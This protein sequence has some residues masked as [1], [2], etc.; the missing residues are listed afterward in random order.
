MYVSSSC[1]TSNHIGQSV[2][3]LA[4]AGVRNIELSGGTSTYDDLLDDLLQLKEK[5]Q[6]NYILHNYFPPPK[7]D[8]VLNLAALDDDIYEMSL[9]HLMKA[10]DM[11][12]KL[13]AARYA[14]HAG[15][16]KRV[17]LN[18]VGQSFILDRLYDPVAAT[19]KFIGGYNEVKEYANRK[20]V[21][22]YLENNVLSHQN[23]RLF[24]EAKSMMLTTSSEVSELSQEISFSLLLDWAHLKVTA[25]SLGLSF[26]EE[27][28]ELAPLSDYWHL[29]DND[30]RVDSNGAISQKGDVEAALKNTL[31]VPEMVTMEI[32]RPMAEVFDSINRVTM[33]LNQGADE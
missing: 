18:E 4:R 32:Y 11:S 3:N 21:E 25:C 26:E 16:F 29:S 12:V 7:K 17:E 28:Q 15:F 30:G 23:S 27:V 2:E 22:L 24:G 9:E 1:Q 31:N 8:F 5:Y 19:E 33:A 20:G 6:L 13:G 10:I 14:F